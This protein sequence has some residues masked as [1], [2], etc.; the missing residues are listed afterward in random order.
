MA[1]SRC[2]SGA[3]SRF[4]AIHGSTVRQLCCFKMFYI[5]SLYFKIRDNRFVSFLPGV[6]GNLYVFE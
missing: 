6:Q 5:N 1:R 2:G 3:Y 4:M